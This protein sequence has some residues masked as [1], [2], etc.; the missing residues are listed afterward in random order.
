VIKDN[1][2]VYE[3]WYP[4]SPER[5]WRALTD[6]AELARW[7]MPSQGFAPVAGQRFSMSCD[8]FGQIEAEI[9]EI[10][11]PRRLVMRWEA[12]FGTTTVRV[13]LAAAG[14]GTALTLVHS[15]WGGEATATRDQFDS[16]WTGKLGPGLRAVLDR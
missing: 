13:E 7:L 2:V 1:A 8:P 9:L 16:G 5:V 11:P 3:L 14:D 15:G 12:V 4:H 10:D 6:P